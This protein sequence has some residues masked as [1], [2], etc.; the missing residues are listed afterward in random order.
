MY[1]VK[2]GSGISVDGGQNPVIKNTGVTSLAGKTGEL[3]LEQGSGITIDG[4]KI[5]NS[6]ITSLASG[7]GISVSGSTITNSDLGSSQNIF[8]TIS[9]SGQTDITAGS[10]TDTLTFTA[11]TGITL[12]T[13]LTGSTGLTISSNDPSVAA[14]W[15][16]GTDSIYLTTST[17]SVGIGTTNPTHK[18][19]V[20]GTGYVSDTLTAGGA[21]S[22]AGTTTLS[23]ALLAN[24]NVTLGDSSSDSLRFIGRIANGTSL[25]PDTDLGADLGSSSL[26]LNNLW[27]ANINSN[28]SQSFAGQTTFSYS[29][30]DT[31]ISQASVLINPTTSAANGQLLALAIAGY[32]RALIDEDGDIILGYSDATSAPATDYPLT[33]YGHSGTLVAYVDTAGVINGTGLG[34]G[35]LSSSLTSTG[36]LNSGSISNGFGAIDTGADNI[37]TTGTIGSAGLTSF[38]GNSLAINTITSTGDISLMPTSNVG[39]GTTAPTQT[40]T[41]LGDVA[42]SVATGVEGLKL[43]DTTDVT[44]LAMKWTSTG[45]SMDI[46]GLTTTN[47]LTNGTFETDITTGGWNQYTLNDQFTTDRAAGAVNGTSAEPTG[48]TRTV[49]DTENY[50]SINSGTLNINRLSNVNYADP[51]INY[52]TITRTVGKVMIWKA[53]VS[54]SQ[55]RWYAGLTNNANGIYGNSI[56]LNSSDGSILATYGTIGNTSA[57]VGSLSLGT[58]YYFA[59][60]LK[61]S[62]AYYYVKGGTYT[63][64]TL[65]YID[66]SYSLSPLYPGMGSDYFY[67]FQGSLDNIR[68]PTSTWLPT[69]LAYDTFTRADGAIGNSETTGPDS[70]TTPSLA[71]TGGAISSNKNVI[72]PSLGSELVTNG[73]FDS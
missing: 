50:L 53:N 12:T 63:N 34:S 71:W 20:A 21:L 73:G 59:V 16:H 58:D 43:T 72:T 14:G 62:G 33:I 25:L 56:F 51:G 18:L 2:A 47:K 57:A 66:S 49:V 45:V 61:S 35:I 1:S 10:N 5:S 17:D 70:Q 28:S 11:G 39:I 19:D 13:D 26:R 7:T 46:P 30:T 27:V 44:K 32:Q 4:L 67:N 41:V 48:G 8:K 65:L 29:P 60:V 55:Y 69:P 64:W 31:T 3:K 52:P 37:V 40:L 36:V 42:S 6:G 68:I 22:V 15:T 23:G 38:T 24:G 54:S 9:V